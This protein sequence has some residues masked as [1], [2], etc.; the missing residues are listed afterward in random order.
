MTFNYP[1][2]KHYRFTKQVL[3]VLNSDHPKG[4]SGSEQGAK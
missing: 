4:S 3:V 1:E 2:Q